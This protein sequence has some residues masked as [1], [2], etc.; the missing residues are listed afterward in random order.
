MDR[1]QQ[2]QGN[3][4]AHYG[5]DQTQW[6][7]GTPQGGQGQAGSQQWQQG[8]QRQ[9]GRQ[10]SQQGG[11]QQQL[12]ARQFESIAEVALRGTALLW[13]LQMETA[14]NVLRTQARTAAMLGIPDCSDLFQIGDE[15]ARRLFSTG[16]EQVLNTARQARETVVE[17]QRQFGRL[18]EQQTIGITEQVRDQIEQIGRQTEQGLQEIR[19]IASSETQQAADMAQ[20]SLDYGNELRQQVDQQVDQQRAARQQDRERAE[21]AGETQQTQANANEW[22]PQFEATSNTMT[23]AQQTAEE[24]E[25]AGEAAAEGRPQRETRRPEE[26]SRAR[27]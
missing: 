23:G 9:A 26:R 16:A 2:R 27:R 21:Q 1:N 5:R 7:G 10:Q 8:G 20:Q 15:R 14:R 4:Q 22:E 11:S 6:R 18:A 3:A 19:E 24:S 13:D 12:G 17:M 25:N